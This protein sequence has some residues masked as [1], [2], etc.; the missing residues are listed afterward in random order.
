MAVMY[1]RNMIVAA[2]LLFVVADAGNILWVVVVTAVLL[3]GGVVV[4]IVLRGRFFASSDT[5][6]DTAPTFTID[7]LRRML[8]CGEISQEE[9]QVLRDQVIHSGQ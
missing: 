3:A 2:S 5:K 4:W 6:Q 9:Y 8:S 1:K 7:Q